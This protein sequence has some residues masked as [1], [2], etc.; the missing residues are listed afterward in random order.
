MMPVFRHGRW[1][2]LPALVVASCSQGPGPSLTAPA[3]RVDTAN[4]AGLGGGSGVVT[5]SAVGDVQNGPIE[6]F[7]VRVAPTGD[8]RFYAN[9]GG[10]YRVDPGVPVEFWVEWRSPVAL[11]RPPRL[12][13]NWGFNPEN[14]FVSCGSCLLNVSFPAG[15]H[16][17]VVTLDDRV[18]GTTKRTFQ[19]EARA[20][21]SDIPAVGTTG[22]GAG[23]PWIVCRADAATAFLSAN[24]GGNYDPTAICR[25]LGYTDYNAHGGTCGTVCGYC[26]TPGL[27][28]YDG[29][30]G[31]GASGAPLSFTVQWRCFR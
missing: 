5:A 24:S 12:I 25:S 3:S 8:N 28:R 15:L 14:D 17:V 7:N 2:I 6:I 31:T 19:I 23:N 4:T 9:P 1:L 20:I 27:E 21:A 10:V 26:G 13:I 29:A 18:G 11:A 22:G 16:T 30:G